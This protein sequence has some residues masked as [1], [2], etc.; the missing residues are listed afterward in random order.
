MRDKIKFLLINPTARV[1]CVQP[2][3]Q[4]SL[5][6]RVFRFS[7]LSSLT[8][9]ASLPEDVEARIVDE[10][11]EAVD[12]N[13]EA[14]IVGISCMTFN[15]PRAYE[16]AD[17]FRKRG[18]TVFLGGYHPSFLPR[19]AILHADAVCIGEAESNLPLMISDFKS[20]NLKQFYK[21]GL[22]DLQG[23]KIPDRSLIK[24][25]KYL[26]A[27]AVQATRGCRN[28]CTYCSIA[29]FFG[30]TFRA[31]PAAEVIGELKTLRRNIIFM[32][33][34]ITTDR[35][36][37]AEL[38]EKMIPLRKN[39]FSQCS[40]T[41]ADDPELLDLA[42]KSGC[43]GLFVG[44]ESLSQ[45]GL[46]KW[47]KDFNRS[48]DYAHS[49]ARLHNQGIAVY[50]GI[51]F[52]NDRDKPAVFSQTL[53]FLLQNKVDALQATILTPFP[54]TPLFAEMDRAGRITDR[55]WSK[56]DFKNVVFRP[57]LMGRDE[58]E[59]GYRRVL[60]RFYSTPSLM[61]RLM[62]EP[63]YLGLRTI[64][65]GSLPLNLSYRYRFRQN[66]IWGS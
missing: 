58:L 35:E 57:E 37:A 4:A 32:D 6:S 39:W 52:G 61:R 46:H 43:R 5:G 44:F 40:I 45:D 13:A 28:H 9:A 18:K 31:R 53:D 66:G 20:G 49:I 62:S 33:D 51:V 59:R 11:V 17:T 25:N 15:A 55:D 27:D 10:E 8:V 22:A 26:W 54:G 16:L 64:L 3:K 2:G 38:F 14:D 1:W 29:A 41:I 65:L 34:N 47:G 19:E 24:G 7:M 60:R 42:A 63:R 36:Y 50:A 30:N 48:H 21:A 56:Y 23:M 12:L